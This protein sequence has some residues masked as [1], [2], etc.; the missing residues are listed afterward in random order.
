MQGSIAAEYVR[1]RRLMLWDIIRRVG[2]ADAEDVLHDIWVERIE[3]PRVTWMRLAVKNHCGR[4]VARRRRVKLGL[5]EW[6]LGA[7]NFGEELERRQLIE[8]VGGVLT[9][10]EVELLLREWDK[11]P[12]AA[13]AQRIRLARRKARKAIV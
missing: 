6:T 2:D 1:R 11:A 8:L 12:P 7:G 5:Q 9:Q 4:L 10:N 13:F 3:N